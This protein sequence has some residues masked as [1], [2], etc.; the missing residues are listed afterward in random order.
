MTFV[1]ASEFLSYQGKIKGFL[2]RQMFV[3]LNSVK[4]TLCSLNVPKIQG[5]QGYQAH[6]GHLLLPLEFRY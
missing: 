6:Q 5:Q 3:S 2:Y 4:H 1:N